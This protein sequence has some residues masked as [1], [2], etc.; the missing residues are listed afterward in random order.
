VRAGV[1]PFTPYTN[2]AN[3]DPHRTSFYYNSAVCK[4][5]KCSPG[6]VNYALANSGSQ[7]I[8]ASLT[9]PEGSAPWPS[10]FHAGGAQFVFVDAH[11]RFVAE[12]IDGSVYAA[13]FSPQG[14]KLMETELRQTLVDGPE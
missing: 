9:E 12:S 4:S 13:L 8:N 6:N 5:L 2:W 11:L 10:S 1:D 3:N 14:Q 7:G